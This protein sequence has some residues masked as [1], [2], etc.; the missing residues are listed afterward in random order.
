MNQTDAQQRLADQWIHKNSADSV[1]GGASAHEQAGRIRLL[2]NNCLCTLS[3]PMGWA[4][5]HQP[6]PGAGVSLLWSI[7][8]A[9]VHPFAISILALLDAYHDG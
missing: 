5:L 8:L 4:E 6:H 1:Q 9:V 3:T 7:T 2:S